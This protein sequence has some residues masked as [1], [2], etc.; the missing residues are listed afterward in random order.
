MWLCGD[1]HVPYEKAWIVGERTGALQML[2]GDYK[3]QHARAGYKD[4]GDLLLAVFP[5]LPQETVIVP[6]PTVASHIRERGYDHTLLVAKYVAKVRHLELCQLLQ[7]KT[8]TK[9]RQATAT[10]RF[11]QAE[12]AFGIKDGRINPDVPYLLIDDV[13]TTGATMK[14]AS[15]ILRKAGAKHVW[16]AAIARQT[17]D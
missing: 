8:D 12:Q 1:C 16:I 11:S 3:F 9:Q 4:L 10:Q 6:I 5:E 14:Y 7:R 2:V 17:L 13:I 15:Q